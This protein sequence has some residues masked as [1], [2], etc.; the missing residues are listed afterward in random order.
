MKEN[1]ITQS[2]AVKILCKS[3]KNRQNNRLNEYL[4]STINANH[5]CVKSCLIV[6]A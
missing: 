3:N 5:L 6:V 4:L 2:S 1:Q